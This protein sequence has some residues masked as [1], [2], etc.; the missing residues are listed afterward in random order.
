MTLL[1]CFHIKILVIWIKS[2]GN[3]PEDSLLSRGILSR[4]YCPGDIVQ[5]ILSRGYCSEAY[6]SGHMVQEDIVRANIV[7]LDVVQGILSGG[8][9]PEVC[10]VQ[11]H[12]LSRSI[13]FPGNIVRGVIVRGKFLGGYCPIDSPRRTKYR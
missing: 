2:W 12:I 7:Q 9:F 10:V 1:F 11:G 8:Y 13:Y 3:C 6:C 5:G 4:G